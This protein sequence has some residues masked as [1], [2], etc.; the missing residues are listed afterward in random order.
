M[1]MPGMSQAA[2]DL[3]L[4]DVLSQQVQGQTEAERKK[5]MLA[6]QQQQRGLSPASSALLG[7]GLGGLGT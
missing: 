1:P 5:R 2:T 6:M 3:G 4:G 7:G